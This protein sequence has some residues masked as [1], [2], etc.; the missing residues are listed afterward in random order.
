MLEAPKKRIPFVHD[1][2]CIMENE[3]PRRKQ[4][5]ISGR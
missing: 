1:D 4:R 5:G 3:L 2:R